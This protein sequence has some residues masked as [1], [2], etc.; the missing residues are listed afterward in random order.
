MF[1]I[2]SSSARLDTR[3][4]PPALVT[5]TH[6]LETIRWKEC[7]GGGGR[8]TARVRGGKVKN[9]GRLKVIL[10]SITPEVY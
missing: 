8:G 10:N 9:T 7:R 1:K 4:S 6:R 2:S 5:P 3:G